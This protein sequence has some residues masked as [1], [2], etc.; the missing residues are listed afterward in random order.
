MKKGDK[1][2][3]LGKPAAS[4]LLREYR[5]TKALLRPREGRAA[6]IPQV[7]SSY[8]QFVQITSTT[9]Q[10]GRYPGTWYRYEPSTDNFSAGVACWVRD[11]NNATLTTGVYYLAREE[12]DATISASTRRTFVPATVNGMPVV[13]ST[14]LTLTPASV[15]LN[16]NQNNYSFGSTSLLYVTPASADR[17]VT[18]LLAGSDGQQLT[19][20]NVGSFDLILA[21]ESGSSSAANQILTGTGASLTVPPDKAVTLTYNGTLAVWVVENTLCCGPT[22]EFT[23]TAVTLGTNQDNYALPSTTILNVTASSAFNFTGF[24]APV[25]AVSQF[26]LL[27]NVGSNNFTLINQSGSSTAGNRIINSFGIDVT[28]VP[29]QVVLLV[30]NPTATRW[31]AYAVPV[32]STPITL[33]ASTATISA[34]TDNLA[35]PGTSL[36]N[37]TTTGATRNLTGI[38]AP[39]APQLIYIVNQGSETLTLVNNATST[40]ANRFQSITGADVSLTNDTAALVL[41]DFSVSRWLVFPI[42]VPGSGGG[43]TGTLANTEVVVA[44]GASTVDSYPAFTFDGGTGQL[45]IAPDANHLIVADGAGL[46]ALYDD[47]V[48]YFEAALGSSAA[49]AIFTDGSDNLVSIG[50]GGDYLTCTILGGPGASD[51]VLTFDATDGFIDSEWASGHLL[52]NNTG[53]GG[54]TTDFAGFQ[55]SPIADASGGATVD[56]EARAAINALLAVHRS[57]ETIDT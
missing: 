39:T 42:G 41:Y 20:H 40:A 26:V 7:T 33:T 56:T 30:Y 35:L 8:T 43:I 15:T 29:S 6:Q 52:A 31:Y 9:K 48:D 22:T 44:T 51:H 11:A 21:N 12:G 18:G 36:L 1:L 57:Q 38:V 34:N 13:V 47:G 49:C 5:R 45:E 55:G 25:P 50:A 2:V 23:A 28:V 17:T 4:Q 19:I 32:G 24:A 54:V 27:T 3:V 46:N 10:S 37:V 53:S 14:T 16:A